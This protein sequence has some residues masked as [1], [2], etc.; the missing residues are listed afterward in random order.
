MFSKRFAFILMLTLIAT[1]AAYSAVPPIISYQGKLMQPSGAAVRDGTYSIQFAIYDVPTGGTALWSETNSS[2]QVK[3]GLFSVLLGSVVNLPVNI[4]DNPDRW[5]AV[6]V[7]TDPE[8]TPRQKIASVG[9]AIKAGTADSAATVADASITTDKIAVGAVTADKLAN[10][11][12]VP[13]GTIVMWSGASTAIPEGWALCDGTNNTPDLRDKFIVGAG[14]SYSTADTGGL[15]SITLSVDQMPSHQHTVDPPA[16]ATDFQGQHSHMPVN[17]SPAF[18]TIGAESGDTFPTAKGS[19]WGFRTAS[20]T[21]EAGNHSHTVDIP[22]FLSAATGGNQP[23]DNRPPYYA[24]CFIM[25]L[26]Y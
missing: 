6:K 24:L 14:L 4:F 23:F 16:T 26:G 7:G 18:L 25:K 8:M 9:Y 5:F 22:P 11:V 3:G 17:Q 10:G 13:P 1:C 12:A 20:G 2:V 21:T 19:D 15:A